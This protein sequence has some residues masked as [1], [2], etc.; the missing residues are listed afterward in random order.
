MKKTI[1]FIVLCITTLSMAQET[2][3]EPPQYKDKKNEIK[4]NALY[5][6]EFGWINLDYERFINKESSFGVSSILNATSYTFL[7]NK[8]LTPYY[9][10]YFSEKFARGFFWE[11]FG[12][13]YSSKAFCIDC[14]SYSGTAFALGISAGG[15]FVSKGG[16]TT[17]VFFG[18]GRNL[19]NSKL[20]WAVVRVGISIG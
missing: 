11:G 14:E 3:S 6:I 12:M 19:T 16:V 10:R 17:E 18:I 1:L 13:L 15:K 4:I 7:I 20:L 8:S 2:I 9:R 5:L